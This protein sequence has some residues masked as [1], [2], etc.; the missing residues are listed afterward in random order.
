M[1]E[2]ICKYSKITDEQL[3]DIKTRKHDW[4]FTPQQ[5]LELGVV[6]KII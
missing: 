2:I 4:Y 3:E 1:K 5:A 6:D